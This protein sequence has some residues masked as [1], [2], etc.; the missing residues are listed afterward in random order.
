MVIAITCL[1]IRLGVYSI[2]NAGYQ[3]VLVDALH[4]ISFGS[5]WGAMSAFVNKYAPQGAESTMQGIL[6]AT[7]MGLGVGI[8]SIV[9]GIMYDSYGP[10][11]MFRYGSYIGLLPIVGLAIYS[12]IQQI[13]KI[14]HVGSC[15]LDTA[16]ENYAPLTTKED[17]RED[18]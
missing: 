11:M 17:I 12:L 10:V 9:S 18:E 15:Q 6:H 13:L 1:S 14:R 8:G 7:S 16:H 2:A 5:G 4:G 3:V